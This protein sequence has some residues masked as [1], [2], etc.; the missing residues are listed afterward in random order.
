M[1]PGLPTL[2][3]RALSE[4]PP[5]RRVL[6]A[7][8]G[9]PDS[10]ALLHALSRLAPREGLELLAHGVDHGL[11]R[12]ARRELDLAAEVAASL[13]TPFTR[14]TLRLDA[15][16]NLQ[17][18]ARLARYAAL[19]EA[20]REAAADAIVTAHH[21]DDRAETVLLRLLRG[22]GA[23][24]LG[25]LPLDA[26]TPSGETRLLRPALRARR[27]DVMSY[28]S[29]HSVPHAQDPSN[30]D[31]RFLRTR[32]RDELLPLLAS[33]SPGVVEHLNALADEQLGGAGAPYRVPRRTLV[34][35][36]ELARKRSPRAR[37]RLP[38]GLVVSYVEEEGRRR[39]REPR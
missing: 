8:S 1:R 36:A 12:G 32:V 4:V 10:M 13:G 23:A 7:V 20:A 16:G 15:G 38:G 6:L 19:D 30:A 35:M 26:R 29:R 31:P 3:R 2:L 9:G 22:A 5:A 21:A 24:G 37:L 39:A 34:A 11:R 28:L 33:L 14:T 27:A 25:V 17:E 18:R